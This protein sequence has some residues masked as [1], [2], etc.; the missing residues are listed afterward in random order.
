MMTRKQKNLLIPLCAGL[1]LAAALAN[2]LVSSS[3][4]AQD[5]RESLGPRDAP[6]DARWKKGPHPLTR[7]MTERNS[8]LRVELR[9]KHPRVYVTDEGLEA[10]RTRA[11][12]THREVWQRVL[13]NL[14]ALKKDPP[15]APAQARRAQNEVGIGIAEAALAFQIERDPKYLAAARRYLDAAVS[16]DVWGYTYNKP[17][18]D[19]AAGHLLYGMGWGYDLLYHDLTEQERTRYRDKI[20]KQARLLADFYKPRP[21]RTYSY[22]QN[23]VFIP[24]AGLGVA[25]YALHDEVSDAPEWARLARAIYDRVLETY[26]ADGYYY[27]GFEYWIFST[28]WLLHYLDA[29]AHTT[30]EDLYDRAGFREMHKYVAHSTLPSGQYASDFGDIYEGPLTRAGK[31]EEYKR[32]HPGGRFHTNYNLL[33]RMASRFRSAE[34]QGVAEWQKSFDQVNAED[35]WSLIWYD[36]SV[37]AVPIEKQK[38]WHHFEDHG[39]VYWRS[40][41]T[42]NATA[43]AFKC[44]PPEGHRTLARLSEIPDWHLSSGHAH[45]DA[46]SFIIYARGQYLTGDSGYAGVPLTAHHNSVLVD[47]RGQ[48]R[49]GNGHDAF[50]GMSYEQLNR[51]RVVEAKLDASSALI[52]GD[53]AAAYD[54]A[55][56]LTRF[57]R[58]FEFNSKGDF[59]ITDY[60]ESATPRTFTM[61]LHADDTVAQDGANRFL[62]DVANAKLNVSVESPEWAL[63]VIEDNVLTAPGPPG[64]V[65]KGERQVRGQRLAVSTREPQTPAHFRVRLNLATQR[66]KNR[67]AGK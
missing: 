55:L 56:G 60:L 5:A 38:R 9:G 19:L 65:D 17:N 43:F 11:R 13:L 67:Q 20:A 26:S 33:Y 29:H 39:V 24:M 40:D 41:W 21:G 16:Y 14:R 42:T 48:A 49:E 44:G 18:V 37:K 45:P 50:A 12:T 63:A 32:T 7:L 64:S 2:P 52:R 46:N 30:G 4:R 53:A 10:L 66:L 6:A 47:G 8:S 59:V 62:I 1:L 25:A 28:P 54:P 57:E 61:L 34:A 15:P 36:P 23:H 22:S 35:Y 31:G 58:R 3:T 27:E 51:I